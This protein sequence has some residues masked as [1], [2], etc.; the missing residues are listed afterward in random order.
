MIFK[1]YIN[2]KIHSSKFKKNFHLSSQKLN[3]DSIQNRKHEV[4]RLHDFINYDE[5][6]MESK[7]QWNCR[8]GIVALIDN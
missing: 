4:D 7:L 3:C 8:N 2:Q 5:N 1:N 6:L